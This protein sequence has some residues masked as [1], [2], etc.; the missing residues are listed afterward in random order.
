[1]ELGETSF[2]D[3]YVYSA[4]G[5]KKTCKLINATIYFNKG[6]LVSSCD[7]LILTSCFNSTNACVYY[8]M[9]SNDTKQVVVSTGPLAQQVLKHLLNNVY[10]LYIIYTF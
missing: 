2:R 5:G 4:A 10:Y 3:K 9:Y 8:I 6:L 7:R 1:M